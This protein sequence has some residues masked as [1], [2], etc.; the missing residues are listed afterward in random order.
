MIYKILFMDNDMLCYVWYNIK[1]GID[2][3]IRI[4]IFLII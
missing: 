3:E 4:V 2:K 1:F